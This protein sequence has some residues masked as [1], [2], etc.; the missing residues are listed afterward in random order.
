MSIT[1]LDYLSA[2]VSLICLGL[3]VCISCLVLEMPCREFVECLSV[4][5][6]MLLRE[7]QQH[8]PCE[9]W[10]FP[11]MFLVYQF[12]WWTHHLIHLRTKKEGNGFPSPLGKQL[13]NLPLLKA[14]NQQ[15]LKETSFMTPC[16]NW[17]THCRINLKYMNHMIP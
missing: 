8:R 13:F 11:R 17:Q 10:I 16:V 15:G 5:P 14:C 4:G 1:R 3:Y 2:V 9:G 12:S 6:V 7:L